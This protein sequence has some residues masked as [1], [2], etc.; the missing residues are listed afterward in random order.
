M[1]RAL[2]T[3]ASG[4]HV[5]LLDIARPSFQAFAG[6]HGYDYLEAEPPDSPRAPSWLKVPILKAA[7]EQGYGEAL[8]IDADCVITDMSEDTHVPKWAWQALVEHHTGDGKVPNCGVWLVRQPMLP[9]LDR[10]WSMTSYLN[11]GWWEQAAMHELLGYQGRPVMHT[12]DTDLFRCTWF[13]GPEWNRHPWDSRPLEGKP[14]RIS[15]A[16]M[17]PDRAK[18]MRQWA[19]GEAVAA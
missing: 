16:T 11:H 1:K 5:E 19:A 6:E 17:W 14:A 18:I 8:W 10:I 13:L 9:I 12:T 3:M 4:P 7:L 2:V 15:H